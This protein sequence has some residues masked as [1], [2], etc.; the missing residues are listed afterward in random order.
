MLERK[1]LPFILNGVNDFFRIKY[2]GDI[3]QRKEYEQQHKQSVA[4]LDQS[5][6]ESKAKKRVVVT[7]HVPSQLC[8]HRDFIFSDIN[9]AF[10]VS[11]DEFIKNHR[12]NY[13]VYGHHHRNIPYQTIGK[14]K[15]VTNQLYQKVYLLE[16]LLL[17]EYI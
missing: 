14:T 5:L 17:S 9:S 1:N 11:M 15:L 2:K 7:H 16:I 8:N 12:I 13:W 4:F 3:I 6:S 10:V